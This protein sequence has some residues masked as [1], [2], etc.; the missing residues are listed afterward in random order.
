MATRGDWSVVLFLLGCAASP[1]LPQ[2]TLPYGFIEDGKDYAWAK[3][4]WPEIKPSRDVDEVIDQLCPAIMK[5]DKANWKDYGQEYCGAIY[6]HGDGIYRASYPSPLGELQ[7][8]GESKT[9]SCYPVRK[10]L[11]PSARLTP[12]LGDYHSHPWFPSPFSRQDK[13]SNNQLWSIKIQ[14]DSACHIQKL[15]PYLNEENRPG[16]LYSRRGKKWVL[17]GL[18]KPENKSFGIVTP[19]DEKLD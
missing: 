11:D 18:I 12:I 2:E 1:P 10:V 17:I 7:L 4:P 9:K 19:V 5:L 3:G 14:F 13:L 15:I 16:E 8:S 6:S